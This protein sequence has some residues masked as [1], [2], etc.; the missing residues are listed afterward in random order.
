MGSGISGNYTGVRPNE[1]SQPYAIA[2]R[3]TDDLLE[4]DKQDPDIYDSISGYF[5]NPTTTNLSEAIIGDG[6]YMG[7]RRMHGK[8]PYVLTEDGKILFGKRSNPNNSSKRAPHPTLIGGKNPKVKCAGMITFSKG[9]VVSVNN[10]SGHFKPNVK[11]M[12]YV[13]GFMNK[14]YEHHPTVFSNMSKWRKNK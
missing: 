1:G 2:Y 10:D 4:R 5:K 14:L 6:V 3:V 9:K 11:S 8:F 7:E 13:N 12:K